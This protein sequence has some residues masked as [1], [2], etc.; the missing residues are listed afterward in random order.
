MSYSAEDVIRRTAEEGMNDLALACLDQRVHELEEIL[1]NT[2]D[3]DKI[4][5]LSDTLDRFEDLRLEIMAIGQ[6]DD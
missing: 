5:E 2:T 4:A 6:G 3:N 1:S